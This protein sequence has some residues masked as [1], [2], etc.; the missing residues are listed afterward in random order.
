MSGKIWS[1]IAANMAC[2]GSIQAHF[3]RL[4]VVPL[5]VA[6]IGAEQPWV[7]AFSRRVMEL[8]F[9]EDRE[10]N[11][12]EVM[13]GILSDLGLPGSAIVEEAQSEATKARLREQTDR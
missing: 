7:G 4:G 10:I 5:R 6:L 9:A 8:N 3:P 11:Q 2:D 13:A 12:P 1:G